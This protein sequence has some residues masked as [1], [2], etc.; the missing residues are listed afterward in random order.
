MS[1]GR[2]SDPSLARAIRTWE[3]SVEAPDTAEQSQS[4]QQR[5]SQSQSQQEHQHAAYSESESQSSVGHTADEPLAEQGSV[6][7]SQCDVPPS[8]RLPADVR[9]ES[10][11]A[12]PELAQ[13]GAECVGQCFP[14]A[15]RRAR[16]LGSSR[17]QRP[18]LAAAELEREQRD[19][20]GGAHPEKRDD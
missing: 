2:A 5:Q 17:F 7:G 1:D 12:T 9:A 3:S 20:E 4:Q 19:I 16:G 6:S 13:P 10:G 15:L 8:R 11:T 14:S 18:F